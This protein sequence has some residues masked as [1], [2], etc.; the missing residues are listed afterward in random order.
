MPILALEAVN[1][2]WK[3]KKIQL[4][5]VTPSGDRAQA[6]HNI[7]F[8]VQHSPFWAN[9]AFACNTETLGSL[10]SHVLLILI[11]LKKLS[12]AWTEV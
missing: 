6:S 8:Q 1:T 5:N 11:K 9:L 3:Q 7:W 10:Y 2:I 12:G 4:Q